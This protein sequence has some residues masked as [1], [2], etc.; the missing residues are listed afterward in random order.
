MSRL[1]A[2]GGIFVLLALTGCGAAEV[3]NE[4]IAAP[5]SAAPTSS[6]CQQGGCATDPVQTAEPTVAPTDPPALSSTPAT[7]DIPAPTVA[8]TPT[9]WTAPDFGPNPFAGTSACPW[10][11]QVLGEDAIWD[12]NTATAIDNGTETRFPG[13]ADFY[14]QA[15]AWWRADL[16]EVNT[17]CH[18]D[19]WTPPTADQAAT[20]ITG[21]Q[22]AT[23]G[24]QADMT[25]NPQDTSWDL[26]WISN[27][28]Y[29]TSLFTWLQND[30]LYGAGP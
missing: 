3:I 16:A 9:P 23:N 17:F 28:T 11:I 30:A 24:H 15:A 4:P 14:R 29:L 13:Q 10:S 25:T 6:D 8:P 20:A 5:A 7:T 27:Y 1:T 22:T 19:E 21:F 2:A 26:Q 12:E 18:N